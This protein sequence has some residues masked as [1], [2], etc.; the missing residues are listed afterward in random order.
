MATNDAPNTPSN[1]EIE[2]KLAPSGSDDGDDDSDGEDLDLD[3]APPLLT[4]DA[5]VRTNTLQHV[6]LGRYRDELVRRGVNNLEDLRQFDNNELETIGM[7]SYV[8]AGPVVVVTVPRCRESTSTNARL[9]LPLL[10]AFL[11]LFFMRVGTEF[12]Q[13]RII[14]QLLVR[15]ELPRT[16]GAGTPPAIPEMV[17]GS[18]EIDADGDGCEATRELP[19]CGFK[20][21]DDC[22]RGDLAFRGK[23][24]CPGCQHPLAA[25]ASQLFANHCCLCSE[26]FVTA[27]SDG[28]TP[29]GGGTPGA[30]GGRLVVGVA[31]HCGFE[32]RAHGRCLLSY[33]QKSI[34]GKQYPIMCPGAEACKCQVPEAIVRGVSQLANDDGSGVDETKAGDVDGVGG[35][36][37]KHQVGGTDIKTRRTDRGDE[38]LG[39]YYA[40]AYDYAISLNGF[41]RQVGEVVHARFCPSVCL[42][43][44]HL[45]TV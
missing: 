33:V 42:S 7:S 8:N 23:F 3:V 28:A 15:A 20:T 38:L 27:A 24:A 13:E 40:L 29:G 21:C 18:C 44:C 5:T 31:L 22:L 39:R 1:D 26:E 25:N 30:A 37:A 32:H 11:R 16:P 2:A 43:Q 6:G 45:V 35:G 19:C 34:K 12:S 17:L 14:F 9:L 4:R 41:L 10:R 36:G